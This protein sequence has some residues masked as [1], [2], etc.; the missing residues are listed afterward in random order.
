MLIDCCRPGRRAGL[1]TWARAQSSLQTA[2]AWKTFKPW[3]ERDNPRFA[4]TVASG[5]LPG[6]AISETKLGW[7]RLMRQEARASLNTLLQ[8]ETILCLPTTPFAAPRIDQSTIRRHSAIRFFVFPATEDSQ[9][10]RKSQFREP[11]FA[12]YLLAFQL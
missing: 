12:A 8:P 2:E 3:I 9:V 11:R 10:Y 6:A 7:A 1:S 5:L 4:F